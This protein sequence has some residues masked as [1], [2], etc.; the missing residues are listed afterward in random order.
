MGTRNRGASRLETEMDSRYASSRLVYIAMTLGSVWLGELV[1]S[2]FT[3]HQFLI[4]P[5]STKLYAHT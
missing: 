1:V 5:Y 3:R 4:T 2:S